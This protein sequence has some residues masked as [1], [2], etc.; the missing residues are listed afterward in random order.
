M[1]C[2]RDWFAVLI[3]PSIVGRCGFWDLS[4]GA[5]ICM[6]TDRDERFIVFVFMLRGYRFAQYLFACDFA[7]VSIIAGI[8]LALFLGLFSVGFFPS[9]SLR[10]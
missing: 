7:G 2:P 3:F 4:L 6:V 9:C 8:L 1:Q 10:N 5:K